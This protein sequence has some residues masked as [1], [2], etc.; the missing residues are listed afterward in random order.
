MYNLLD[1]NWVIIGSVRE[2]LWA[3]KGLCKKKKFVKLIPLTIFWVIWKECNSGAFD[4]IEDDWATI[5]DR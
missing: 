1:I 3:W 2:Q 4:G 5:R